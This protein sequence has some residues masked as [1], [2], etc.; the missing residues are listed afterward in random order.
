MSGKPQKE[1]FEANA[2]E[3]MALVAQAFGC[4]A[5]RG[6]RMDPV[7]TPPPEFYQAMHA[8]WNATEITLPATLGTCKLEHSAQQGVAQRLFG[9]QHRN[10]SPNDKRLPHHEPTAM[11]TVNAMLDR[12]L[13]CV[14]WEKQ[15]M[16]LCKQHP[17]PENYAAHAVR[18]QAI[19]GMRAQI[20]PYYYTVLREQYGCDQHAVKIVGESIRGFIDTMHCTS[21]NAMFGSV[22]PQPDTSATPS[23][24]VRDITDHAQASMVNARECVTTR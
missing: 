23:M 8:E 12:Y 22:R 1:D 16:A 24:I 4:P 7:M 21:A 3:A 11:D 17:S 15:S 6:D 19:E 18:A 5:P 9:A 2:R 20:A 14:Y 10:G 13:L